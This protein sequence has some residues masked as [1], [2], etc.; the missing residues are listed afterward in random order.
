M[1]VFIVEFPFIFYV[2]VFVE[3]TLNSKCHFR[4]VIPETIPKKNIKTMLLLGFACS[5]TQFRRRRVNRAHTWTHGHLNL[6]KKSEHG[7][8]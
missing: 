5:L 1:K 4:T 8:D 2:V 7:M 6:T 3:E